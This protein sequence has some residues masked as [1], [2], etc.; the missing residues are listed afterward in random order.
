MMMEMIET[1]MPALPGS[2]KSRS[3]MPFDPEQHTQSIC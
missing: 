1:I 3:N 2:G